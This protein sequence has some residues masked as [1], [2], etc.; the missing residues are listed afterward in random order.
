MPDAIR[1]PTS[2]PHLRSS[3]K[4]SDSVRLAPSRAHASRI[5]STLPSHPRAAPRRCGCASRSERACAYAGALSPPC[6]RPLHHSM[7]DMT[8]PGMGHTP[9]LRRMSAC[10]GRTHYRTSCLFRPPAC[11][12]AH[13]TSPSEYT[14]A[15]ARGDLNKEGSPAPPPIQ[16]KAAHTHTHMPT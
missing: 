5:D 13:A 2:A 7:Q 4:A 14:H 11:A 12:C 8:A 9:R 3:L 6:R 1:L 16:G 15:P 10:G